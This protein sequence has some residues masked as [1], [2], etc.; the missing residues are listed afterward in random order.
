MGELNL[1]LALAGISGF[2]L[3]LG[4]CGFLIECILEG[5]EDGQ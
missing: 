1:F 2:S 3:F 5:R 4:I